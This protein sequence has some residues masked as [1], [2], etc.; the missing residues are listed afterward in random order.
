MNLHLDVEER[1]TQ[2]EKAQKTHS[3]EH[4]VT[5]G[6]AAVADLGSGI[7]S[8]RIL[9]N[10]SNCTLCAGAVLKEASDCIH[11]YIERCCE[12]WTNMSVVH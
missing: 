7:G 8:E 10:Q 12:L 3:L 4:D 9:A 2:I 11:C 5:L 6:A 1:V